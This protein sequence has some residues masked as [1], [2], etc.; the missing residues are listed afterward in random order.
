MVKE[1]KRN[2]AI[3]THGEWTNSWAL[4]SSAAALWRLC[5]C[6]ASYCNGDSFQCGRSSIDV[7]GLATRF[8][9]GNQG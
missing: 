7:G 1:E 5:R 3:K 9:G 6:L 8:L 4:P 2:A